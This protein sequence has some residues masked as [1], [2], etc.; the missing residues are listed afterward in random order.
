VDFAGQF[1]L[2]TYPCPADR[3]LTGVV[4]DYLKNPVPGATVQVMGWQTPPGAP[5]PNPATT[6]A[7]GTYTITIAWLPISEYTVVATLPNGE[8]ITQRQILNFWAG[9]ASDNLTLNFYEYLLVGF[10]YDCEGDP[11]ANATVQ[12]VGWQTPPGDPHPNP[13]TTNASGAYTI[14][15]SSLPPGDYQVV[16]R[17]PNGASTQQEKHL[18]STNG[19]FTQLNFTGAFCLPTAFCPA[20]RRLKGTV[21]NYLGNPVPGAT[22]EILGWQTP[23]GAPYP[24]PATTDATGTYTIT[25]TG[26]PVSTYSVVARW[27]TGTAMR[28]EPASFWQGCLTGHLQLDLQ[29]ALLVGFTY[30]C[31]GNPVA[32]ARVNVVGWQTLAGD[33]H[34][35]PAFTDA[36]GAYTVTI[37]SLPSGDYQVV[38]MHPNGLSIQQ[39]KHLDGTHG[40][41]TQ[42][43]FTGVFCLPT[44]AVCP[45]D[46]LLIGTVHDFL[47]NPV[48]GATVQILGWQ[49][50]PGDPYP[51][52]ATTDATGTYTITIA[53]LPVSE[54]TVVARLPGGGVITETRAI[55][56]W[57]E[58][59]IGDLQL[60]FRECILTGFVYDCEGIPVVNATV[61]VVGWQTSPGDPH[62]NPAR[63]D[64]RGAY[65]I[66]LSSLPPGNYPVIAR[67][68]NG[69]STQQQVTLDCT[70]GGARQL[71]FTGTFCV[72]GAAPTPTPTPTLGIPQCGPGAKLVGVVQDCAGNP[73]RN[74]LVQIEGEGPDRSART[75]EA[76]QY[77]IDISGLPIQ[78]YLVRV[79]AAGFV[80]RV[81]PP[82]FE[83]FWNACATPNAQLSMNFTGP[84]CL[85]GPPSVPVVYVPVL[86]SVAEQDGYET[87]IQVQ[88]VGDGVTEVT[89][90]LWG[91]YSGKCPPQAPGRIETM[92][93]GEIRPG[94][95]WVWTSSFFPD[96]AR[97]ARSAILRSTQPIAVEVFRRGPGFPD[98]GVEVAGA[99]AGLPDT[100]LGKRDEAFGGY[101][102]YAPIVYGFSGGLSSWLYIQNAGT[103]CTS[104]EIYFRSQESCNRTVIGQVRVLAP[105]EAVQFPAA[106][107]VGGRWQGSA[108]LSAGQPLAIAVDHFGDN[109]LMSYVA[110]PADTLYANEGSTP[111]SAGSQVNYGPL[112][113]REFQG[114]DTTIHVQNLSSVIQAKVKV[115]F[116]DASGDIIQTIVDWICPRGTQRFFLPVINNLPGNF[117][118]AVRV[119]SQD[120]WSPG[121]PPVSYP[122]IVSVAE[123]VKYEGPARTQRLEAIAYNLFTEDTAFDWQTG[124]SGVKLV[125]IPSVVKYKD[126]LTSEI[127]IQNV[128]PLPGFTDLALFV[129]DQ[130][131]LLDFHC[132]KLNA[133]QVEYIDLNAWPLVP[134]NFE[135]SLVISATYWNHPVPGQP[136]ATTAGIAAVSILRSDTTLGH[137]FPGDESAGVEAFPVPP[138][139]KF[140]GPP[141]SPATCPGQP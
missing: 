127:A 91:E 25:L 140:S 75:N 89:M 117:V 72:P 26:L 52:P 66:T 9:C 34:P 120:W 90:E 39:Q 81:Q 32:G 78:D 49:T 37:S 7:T 1:C 92:R 4:Y 99:Y 5:Y 76:G 10:V 82:P 110:M 44:D 103:K 58:C 96:E 53:G 15:A 18:D 3:V 84:F 116:L 114:W 59:R 125:G 60:D 50:P 112:I 118:G 51:N 11:V 135:G 40:G 55:S 111:F 109:V 93:S 104:V 42:L 41:F 100:L 138:G 38:A 141:G 30:D 102:Y 54:Y 121:D 139:F 33:P 101:A 24:N 108:W 77:V 22:V 126:G 35:N 2:P 57:A 136:G 131:R 79:S 48:A 83:G 45:T 106:S 31:L 137:D 46:R 14:T 87:W 113:Y 64:A 86:N 67:H 133:K 17:H 97:E 134:R 122:P 36:R 128:N 98:S 61:E 20:D 85:E 68:P 71:N 19:G 13:A 65:T 123:L 107:T 130:N 23:P 27:P 124:L 95:S 47:G 29:E 132:E 16:A 119:E 74:A 56:F 8:V 80:D 129:Y 62:P 12:I 28:T 105:G 21:R 69:S 73:I 6:D 88:N 94:S 63:T 43:N 70:T 115:H